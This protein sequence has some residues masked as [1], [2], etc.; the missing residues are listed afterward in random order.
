MS[1]P[2]FNLVVEG[3]E[4]A[5]VAF[6]L[7]NEDIGRR[8]RA[9]VAMTTSRVVAGAKSR[10]H[11]RSG[12][13]AGTIRGELLA[14]GLVGLAKVGYGTL[15]RRSRSVAGGKRRRSRVQGPVQPGIYAMVVEY[16]DQRNNKPAEP[17]MYPAA[18]AELPGYH[19]GLREDLRGAVVKAESGGSST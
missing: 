6:K 1:G 15:K 17:F 14:G 5:V 18:D 13:L 16:G 11:K 7:A 19:E 9:R 12:E 4:R 3:V 10:V 2:K 8:V